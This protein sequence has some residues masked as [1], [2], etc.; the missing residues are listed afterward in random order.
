MVKKR[1]KP[2]IE[3]DLAKVEVMAANGLTQQQIADSLGISVSTLY[4]RKR[5]S[6]EFEEAIK[7]G[8]AKGVALVTNE[9]MKQVK[10]GNVTAMIFFLKAR[11]GWKEKNEVDLTN[12]DGS[13]AQPRKLQDLFDNEIEVKSEA[14]ASD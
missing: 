7:R 1:T 4:G 13:F 5:E 9:L 12:S 2:K 10:S 11:A 6:E 3:I 8:K 14:E